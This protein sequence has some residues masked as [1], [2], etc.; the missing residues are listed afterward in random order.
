[1]Q[2]CSHRFWMW[3][4]G[5]RFSRRST[6]FWITTASCIYRRRKLLS[7]HTRISASSRPKTLPGRTVDG[8]LFPARSG[9]GSWRCVSSVFCCAKHLYPVLKLFCVTR[10]GL[11]MFTRLFTSLPTREENQQSETSKNNGATTTQA[12]FGTLLMVL[13][14]GTFGLQCRCRIMWRVQ[15][16]VVCSLSLYLLV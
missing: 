10:I 5:D 4:T 13:C 1:M 12:S 15:F 6:D 9:I 3:L 16:D 8:S 2:F 7:G 14:W 11:V